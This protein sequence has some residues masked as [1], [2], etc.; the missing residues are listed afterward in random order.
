M[1]TVYENG[2]WVV[3]T[4]EDLN[5]SP[6]AIQQ[7]KEATVAERQLYGESQY[8]NQEFVNQILNGELKTRAGV[9]CLP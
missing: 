5:P 7:M 9:A 1:Y 8:D 2:K 6:T 3:K 4:G